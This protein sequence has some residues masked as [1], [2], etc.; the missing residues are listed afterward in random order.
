[1]S[2]KAAFRD[3]RIFLTFPRYT[4]PTEKLCPWLD[5]L[6]SSISLWFSIRA[7]ETSVAFTSTIRSFTDSI[8]IGFFETKKTDLLAGLL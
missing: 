6:F 4:S 2:T 3:G 7:I 1:M 8:T 5:S